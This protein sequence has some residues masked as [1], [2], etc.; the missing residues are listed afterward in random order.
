[1]NQRVVLRIT[2]DLLSDAIFGSG[3][4]I[5]GGENIAVCQDE[6]GFPYL[7][8]STFKGLLRESLENWLAWTNGDP[9]DLDSLLGAE[10]WQGLAGDRRIQLTSFTLSDAPKD[11]SHCYSTRVFTSL[12]EG[13]TKKKTLRTASC[14]VKGLR[15][16]GQ[17]LCQQ[18]D[19]PLL[20]NV[21]A[22][23]KW[24]G[25]LRS[26]GFGRVRVQSEPIFSGEDVPTLPEAKCIRYR[27][28]TQMPVLI[29]HLDQS[30]GNRYETRS[31]IPGS[32]VRGMVMG[33]LSSRMPEWFELHKD[34]LLSHRTR[35]LDALPMDPEVERR[36]EGSDV[37]EYGILPSLKGFVESRDGGDFQCS[38][39]GGKR[40]Q[41]TKDAN[42]GSFCS[43]QD[44]TLHYWDAQTGGVTR[45][46]RNTD[47][48]EDTLPFQ[49]RYLSAGQDFEGII[50]LDDPSL[51]PSIGEAFG[52][53]IWLGADRYEGFGQCRVIG[54]PE[55]IPQPSWWEDYGY[56]MQDEV[57]T[58]L[59]LLVLS[60]LSMVDEKGDPCGIDEVQLAKA[61]GVGRARIEACSTSTS[62][63]G[64]FNRTWQCWSPSVAMYDRGSLFRICCDAAPSRDCILDIQRRGLGMRAS[65]GYGQVL[66]LRPDLL[67]GIHAKREHKPTRPS[68]DAQAMG[69]RRAKYQWVMDQNQWVQESRLSKSQFGTIQSLCEKAMQGDGDLKELSD[70]FKK[71]I[72]NRGA[73]QSRPFQEAFQR[74]WGILTKPLDETLG[75]D[76]E[77]SSQERL[78]LLC[79][80]L[81]YSRKGAD[82][83]DDP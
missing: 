61:L 65:E 73:K 7:K 58:S 70:Y 13:V 5:P 77:D 34:V 30:Y 25:T 14:I 45:I 66:F 74:I 71:N 15:F 59:Y 42:I 83:R 54:G 21:L 16:C 75:L 46:Q 24:I 2:I 1:M 55:S 50:L 56:R 67:T 17:L 82:G 11:V 80:L 39:A 18:Q 3:Y 26:R 47:P 32:A 63:Y 6:K 29:T 72:D 78:K 12:E 31:Y 69:I 8:G 43:L 22:G 41:G 57:G 33:F 10:D 9:Q 79:M 37:Q 28:R 4:S 36:D 81:D 27:L 35:F 64:S 60:P 38:I 62:E 51:A 49:T 19:V 53:S 76:C 20:Q 68:P 40:P 52:S 44:G 23:I 48:E